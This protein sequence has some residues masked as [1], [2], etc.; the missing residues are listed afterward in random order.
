[1][2]DDRECARA[3]ALDQHA[4]SPR[5]SASVSPG[6]TVPASWADAGRH[7]RH[8]HRGRGGVR[9]SGRSL[10]G[11][12]RS[13]PSALRRSSRTIFNPNTATAWNSMARPLPACD[14]HVLGIF[15]VQVIRQ[16]DFALIAARDLASAAGVGGGAPDMQRV[17]YSV[18]AF[19]VCVGNVSKL[20][21]PHYRKRDQRLANRGER[22]R[23]VLD[24]DTL[25]V[26]KLRK[27]PKRLRALRRPPGI[28]GHNGGWATLHRWQHQRSSGPSGH[29]SGAMASEPQYAGDDDH[30]LRGGVRAE[31][32]VGRNPGIAAPCSCCSR[33]S[34]WERR[35]MTDSADVRD[36]NPERLR[37]H[38]A[39]P[40][41]ALSQKAPLGEAS[42]FAQ[43]DRQWRLRHLCGAH[44]VDR[45]EDPA[46]VWLPAGYAGI[47]HEGGVAAG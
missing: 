20:I 46:K 10:T 47:S 38:P 3:R 37:Q 2:S 29:P 9:L 14:D 11:T 27:S 30:V 17:W 39:S 15:L 43:D 44:L 35:A 33:R 22:L 24:A 1:M 6:S 5:N 25:E 8:R 34:A 16:A 18:Q 19:L 41:A 45:E 42:A 21:W 7:R 23:Q 31:P 32:G 40:R 12:I 13:P 36:A 26:L 28:L 4:R